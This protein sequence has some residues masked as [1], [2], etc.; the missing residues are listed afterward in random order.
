MTN[1][2]HIEP[3][4][5]LH[6][7]NLGFDGVGRN[8]FNLVG[9]VGNGFFLPNLLEYR[10]IIFISS[11]KHSAWFSRLFCLVNILFQSSRGE[12]ATISNF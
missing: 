6:F 10:F 5:C 1:N 2:A 11:A 7:I 4:V 12:N 8:Q 3:V 9:R